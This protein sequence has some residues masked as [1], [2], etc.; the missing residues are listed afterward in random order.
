MLDVGKCAFL[1]H[2]APL[3]SRPALAEGGGVQ[4]LRLLLPILPLPH[5]H[6]HKE[7]DGLGLIPWSPPQEPKDHHVL[8]QHW[9]LIPMRPSDLTPLQTD[10]SPPRC[11]LNRPSVAE[12]TVS[13]VSCSKEM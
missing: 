5:P 3:A 7:Q 6:P 10:P 4:S 13:S 12:A 2:H 8:L 1:Y 11:P 9:T